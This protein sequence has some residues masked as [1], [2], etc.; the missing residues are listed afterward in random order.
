[1]GKKCRFKIILVPFEA[2]N[3]FNSADAWRKVRHVN[4]DRLG[5]LA[6]RE[7]HRL[8]QIIYRDEISRNSSKFENIVHVSTFLAEKKRLELAE[9]WAR[10]AIQVNDC[11]KTRKNLAQILCTGKQFYEIIFFNIVPGALTLR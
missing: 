6:D 1:L 4:S 3:N 2:Q 9:N 8:E 10:F 5:H 11:V 7:A